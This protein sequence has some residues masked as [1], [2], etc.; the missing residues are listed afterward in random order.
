MLILILIA[1]ASIG[2]ALLLHRTSATAASGQI[3]FFDSQSGIS[4]A[5]GNTDA[6]TFTIN[7]LPAPPSGSQ[8]NAWLINDQNEQIIA[9]GALAQQR[10]ELYAPLYR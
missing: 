1:G 7:N 8:Y 10:T 3:T 9:L 4:G 5:A 6:L 2:G